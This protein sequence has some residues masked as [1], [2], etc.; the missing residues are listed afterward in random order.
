M[1]KNKY[2]EK[3]RF[4]YYYENQNFRDFNSFKTSVYRSALS[5]L[6]LNSNDDKVKSFLSDVLSFVEE[7]EKVFCKK[8]N[9]K[10]KR[11]E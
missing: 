7:N 4:K 8:N 5:V 3:M 2:T 11:E 1:T 6:Y 9:I 10:Y